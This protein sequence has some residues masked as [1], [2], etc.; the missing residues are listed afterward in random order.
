[1]SDVDGAFFAMIPGL[2]LEVLSRLPSELRYRF[3][4]PDL[5]I[6][7]VHSSLIVDVLPNALSVN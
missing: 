1:M 2:I 7:D 3:V 4:G 6:V 5:A